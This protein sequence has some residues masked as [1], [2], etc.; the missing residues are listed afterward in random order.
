M[1]DEG[2]PAAALAAEKEN[3]EILSV[4]SNNNSGSSENIPPIKES[5]QSS[6]EEQRLPTLARKHV[7]S[8]AQV[9]FVSTICLPFSNNTSTS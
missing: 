1:I 6:T 5:A 4:V 2:Q 9:R 8:T 3:C 7:G